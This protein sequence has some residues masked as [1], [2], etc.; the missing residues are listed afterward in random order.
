VKPADNNL[1]ARGAKLSRY[2]QSA[3]KLISLHPNKAD[4]LSVVIAN[5][6]S[7]DPFHTNN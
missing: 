3:S 1:D 6:T 2:I 5:E 7:N 4:D